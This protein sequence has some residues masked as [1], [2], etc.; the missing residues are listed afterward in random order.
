MMIEFANQL[1]KYRNDNG[2]TQAELATKLYGN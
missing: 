1:K 2:V